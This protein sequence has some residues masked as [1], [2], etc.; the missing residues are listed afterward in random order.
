MS[1]VRVATHFNIDIEFTAPPFHRRLGAWFI[2]VVV[3]I[4]YTVVAARLLAWVFNQLDY[5]DGGNVARWALNL[6]AAL[7][8]LLYHVVMEATVNGQSVGKKIM[9]IRVISENGTRPSLGQLIIRWLVRTSDYMLLILILVIGNTAASG[10]APSSEMVGAVG[11]TLALLVTDLVLVNT[12]KQQRLGDILAHTVLIN[13]RQRE[14]ITDTVFLDVEHDYVP[15]FPQIMQLSDR[16]MNSLK[17]IIEAARKQRDSKMASIAAEKI[18]NHLHIE[19]N[20]EPQEFLEIL[21]K[22][23]N[24]LAAN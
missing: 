2:D 14:K 1:T 12:R 5:G 16:D 18:K 24:F 19:T 15:R 6:L 10:Q 21:L 13:T 8:F 22:D 4:L 20:L 23:Y 11:L 3:L 17:G 7:P 9:S